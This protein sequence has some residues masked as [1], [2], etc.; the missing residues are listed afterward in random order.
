MAEKF[1]QDWGK[2]DEAGWR[3]QIPGWLAV[4]MVEVR[5]HVQRLEQWAI[6]LVQK[7]DQ[8]AHDVAELRHHVRVTRAGDRLESLEQAATREAARVTALERAH[9]HVADVDE[10]ARQVAILGDQQREQANGIGDHDKTLRVLDQRLRVLEAQRTVDDEHLGRVAGEL[11]RQGAQGAELEARVAALERR[12]PVDVPTVGD[13]EHVVT[14][15]LQQTLTPVLERV[16]ALEPQVGVATGM[17]RCE[18]VAGDRRCMRR[19]GHADSHRFVGVD[20]M[21]AGVWRQVIE[22]DHRTEVLEARPSVTSLVGVVLGRCVYRAQ[23]TDTPCAAA[24]QYAGTSPCDDRWRCRRYVVVDNPAVTTEAEA[25]PRTGLRS[26]AEV[27]AEADGGQ[28]DPPVP[29]NKFLPLPP[30]D[31]LRPTHLACGKKREHPGGCQYTLSDAAVRAIDQAGGALRAEQR[32]DAAD[33]PPVFSGDQADE[34]VMD[35]HYK[36]QRD[37]DPLD[38]AGLTPGARALLRKHL[39]GENPVVGERERFDAVPI[40]PPRWRR[41]QC[42]L[43]KDHS[44]P[45]AYDALNQSRTLPQCPVRG[46]QIPD[47]VVIS[48]TPA[49]IAGRF[50]EQWVQNTRR[51][52]VW[53]AA[54]IAKAADPVD[55][56]RCWTVANAHA[57]EVLRDYNPK[58]TATLAALHLYPLN[59]DVPTSRCVLH[60]DHDAVKW[61]DRGSG[62]CSVVLPWPAQHPA[63]EAERCTRLVAV[64]AELVAIAVPSGCGPLACVLQ[65]GHDG[66]HRRTQ[67]VAVPEIEDDDEDDAT[68]RRPGQCMWTCR[69]MLADD[70]S[71]RPPRRASWWAW[72]APTMY[73]TLLPLRNPLPRVREFTTG[74]AEFEVCVLLDGHRESHRMPA[75]VANSQRASGEGRCGWTAR[76]GPARVRQL[77]EPAPLIRPLEEWVWS[78]PPAPRCVR[79]ADHD[80]DHRLVREVDEPTVPV[81]SRRCSVRVLRFDAGASPVWPAA[82][83]RCVAT[84]QYGDPNREYRCVLLEWH[85]AIDHEYENTDRCR[86][87]HDHPGAPHAFTDDVQLPNVNTCRCPVRRA[88]PPSPLRCPH[89]WTAHHNGNDAKRHQ[90]L[91]REG[92]AGDHQYE[93]LQVGGR[94]PDTR[95]EVMLGPG[96]GPVAQCVREWQHVEFEHLYPSQPRAGLYA[97]DRLVEW[98][99]QQAMPRG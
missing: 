18:E 76:R 90:C 77:G 65:A 29:C 72:A 50:G 84:W 70:R 44:E 42:M 54:A 96:L 74:P 31:G 34:L 4:A 11:N 94:C 89:Y 55:V 28:D 24:V 13:V 12:P 83:A 67:E 7:Y 43:P 66:D 95:N 23:H 3:S 97:I 62:P 2:W 37:G 69:E 68:D 16:G 79:F 82:P 58:A 26:S 35:V 61:S 30:G 92:H 21:L 75:Q 17:A 73:T 91:G 81:H 40:P 20:E 52:I 80:G 60:R 93:G 46:V 85:P 19:Y 36:M 48:V 5:R 88:R 71:T 1:P 10:Y 41:V 15:V 78:A 47:D 22:Q 39:M 87:P 14:R 63:A 32:R 53:P 86:Q 45:H 57:G 38:R 49:K 98:Y 99:R 33:A 59:D 51:A 25:P 8:V 64:P 9:P 56:P 6:D 27:R